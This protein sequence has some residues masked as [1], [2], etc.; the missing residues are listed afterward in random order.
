MG[1]SSSRCRANQ[2]PSC[3]EAERPSAQASEFCII[4][5]SSSEG[6]N[7]EQAE[8]CSSSRNSSTRESSDESLRQ[9]KQ[10]ALGSAEIQGRR[11]HQPPR[12]LSR[13]R[14]VNMDPFTRPHL[15]QSQ[16]E[17]EDNPRILCR[18]VQVNTDTLSRF[19][20][21]QSERLSEAGH[22]QYSA[23]ELQARSRSYTGSA[24]SPN[25]VEAESNSSFMD[26]MQRMR[27]EGVDSTSQTR[28]N[29]FTN[30]D[31]TNR[32]NNTRSV[33]SHRGRT[34]SF[35]PYG[36]FDGYS[37]C[38][39]GGSREYAGRV[40]SGPSHHT[41]LRGASM[42]RG[43]STGRDNRRNGGRR[44]WD[45]LTRAA[46]QRRLSNYQGS[47][48]AADRVSAP[49]N[50]RSTVSNRRSEIIA[51]PYEE[52]EERNSFRNRSLNLDERRRRFRSQVWA[53]QRL[54]TS[55]EGVPGHARPCARRARHESV[56]RSHATTQTNEE[57]DT[58]ASISRIIMLAEALF[59]VLDEIHRQS[60]ALSQSAGLSLGSLRAPDAVV[61]SMPL[62]IFQKINTVE[63]KEDA[64]V[65]CHICLV[66]YEGGD[67]LRVLPCSHEY[68]MTCIDKWL[69]EVHRVCPLCRGDV[70][71]LKATE[72]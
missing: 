8:R 6:S 16:I 2:E 38:D 4:G 31:M 11:V 3:P 34:G 72:K 46:S 27:Q 10:E 37:V 1:L 50:G 39:P 19:P 18:T 62:R 65:Q 58:R 60:V 70:C 54:S 5:S 35:Q 21:R 45:A 48:E 33:S 17:N 7:V 29:N 28:T 56:D 44:F 69:R 22:G 14:Q 67:H 43:E 42:F 57:T 64:A 68:H 53:L 15:R 47:Q 32:Y 66:E 59:Q 12:I 13:T 49:C 61:E 40:A 71:E 36:E 41:D 30:A 63:N 52:R 55:F 25:V 24:P 26:V 23:E 20:L 9:I 51:L